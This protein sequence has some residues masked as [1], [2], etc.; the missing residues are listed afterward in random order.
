[1]MTLAQSSSQLNRDAGENGE[2]KHEF[3]HSGTC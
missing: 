3:L 1:M 2:I